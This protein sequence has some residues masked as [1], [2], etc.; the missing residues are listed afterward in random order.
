MIPP[1]PP[2][3]SRLKSIGL[4]LGILVITLAVISLLMATR[5]RLEVTAVPERVW[6]VDAIVAKRGAIQPQLNLFGE[7]AAGRRSELRPAVSGKMVRIGENFR[8]G[9]TVTKGELLVQ[10][11]P[12]EYQTGL[13]EQR[14]ML[15]ESK[16]RL[17]M[18]RRELARAAELYAANNVSEQFLDEAELEV[19]QQE[20]LV[21]Q[22]EIGVRRAERDL[23][24][25][26][27]VAPFD[28]VVHN[29]NAALGKH[30]SGFGADMV[31][32]LIDTSQIEV[33]FTLSNAQYGRLLENG[34][35]I[36]GRAATISW[37][38]G[39]SLF[40]YAAEVRRVG[41]QITSTTGG[42][43]AYAVIAPGGEQLLLRP[44]AFV[45]VTLLDKVFDDAFQA[46]D[47]ALYGDDIV[48][49]V[50]D[51]RLS[52]RVVQVVGYAGN[53]VLLSSAGDPPLRN[54]DRIVITQLREAGS[55]AKVSVRE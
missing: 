4:P 31:G 37:E 28:G 42:I 54:G 12:F 15:K 2:V 55:G 44:G 14:S 19:A 47:T 51:E 43:E 35:S 9:G 38:V 39:D 33:R 36:V 17:E 32:E 20:A 45:R 26:T 48:Y 6:Y 16:V 13:D 7:V 49:V 8:E 25:A 21:E 24:E 34:A 27:L 11:D 5:P 50:E 23:R 1:A 46:P 53:E 41:G 52:P 10:I 3:R 18:L 40:E 22:R 30:F 29:V